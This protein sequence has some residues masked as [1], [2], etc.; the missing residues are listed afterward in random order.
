MYK[1]KLPP[2]NDQTYLK[3]SPLF[4]LVKPEYNALRNIYNDDSSSEKYLTYQ[5][6]Q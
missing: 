1:N 5:H 4:T 3:I 2:A 6:L